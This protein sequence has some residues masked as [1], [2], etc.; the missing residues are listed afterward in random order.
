[1]QGHAVKGG[2]MDF[3]TWLAKH[4]P[5]VKPGATR[6]MMRDAWN[7]ALSSG[8]PGESGEDFIY[9]SLDDFKRVWRGAINPITALR[10]WSRARSRKGAC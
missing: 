7:A 8:K 5:D 4:Y 10:L 9:D 1:M 6:A 3:E 2:M